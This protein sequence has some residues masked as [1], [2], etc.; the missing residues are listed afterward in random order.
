MHNRKN[1]RR[2]L[3][4]MLLNGASLQM[5]A[6]RR[7]GK[8]WIM[9]ELAKDFR[10]EGWTVVLLDV[11]GMR[12]EDEFLRAL[13]RE[14]EGA[15]NV[16]ANIRTNLL[17][18]LKSMITDGWT[19]SPWQAVGKIDFNAFS[20]ALIAELNQSGGDSVIMVDEIALFVAQII[21]RDLPAANAFLYQLR[22][23]RQ[24]YT[25]VRWLF[26]GSIGLDVVARRGNLL[27]AL[28]DLKPFVL[29]PF[30][31][32]AARS[33]LAD[34]SKRDLVPTPFTLD[35]AAFAHLKTELGWLA[36]FY[37]QS[38]ADRI[39]PTGPNGAATVADVEAAF[40][41]ML[42][43]E[44]RTLFAPFEEHIE[45]N[46]PKAESR[47]LAAILDALCEQ[48]AGET[49][50][51]LMANLQA[52]EPEIDAQGLANALTALSNAGLAESV[53]ERWRFR[54]GLVRRYWRRY[55]RL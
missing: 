4:K 24:K 43:P 27:G 39:R 13:S 45:K 48:A 28:V 37:L 52:S 22:R 36:P 42:R 32:A 38:I 35:D 17:Y 29:A 33:Y 8:T 50:D 46:F 47:R 25:K 41:E 14:I 44:F 12:S 49:A 1:E 16:G 51:T 26:T 15:G 30:D 7:I 20:E 55:H 54:S 10:A 53:N 40:G 3:R 2:E 5:F 23:L 9:L 34:L 18:R 11:E 6:P 31:E 19:G 21:D